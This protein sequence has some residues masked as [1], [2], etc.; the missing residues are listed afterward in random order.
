MKASG[1]K[2]LPVVMYHYVNDLQGGITVTA[3]CFEE[4]C[5]VLAQKG[6]RGIGLDEAE[7]FLINGKALPAR[8]LLL[9][10]DDGY[11]D[12][13]LNALPAMRR[14]GHRGVVFAVAGRLEPGAEPR[15]ALAK[16]LQG[17]A[18]VPAEV[19]VPVVQTPEGF[20]LRKDVF[21]NHAEAK[22]MDAEGT[23]RVA[24][25]SF[26]HYGVYLGPDYTGVS[27]PRTR[28]RTFYRTEQEPVWGLPEFKV[29]PGLLERA[30]IP[31]PSLV[32]AVKAL[33]PQE[34][35]AAAAFFAEGGACE[36]LA[37]L[38]AGFAGKL[39]RYESDA[40]RKERMWREL[41]GG[42]EALEMVLG[43]KVRT[44]CWPWGKYCGEALTLAREA[45]FEL[46]FS[47]KEG[48]N[49]PG[50]PLAVHRFKGKPKSGNWLLSR[51]RIYASPLLGSM[52][53]RLRI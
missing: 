22:A 21:L 34:F 43:H 7:D 5:R 38:L 15:A 53:A 50:R 12:N 44:L 11:L 2:S 39:G 23:L 9:T 32:E 29:G 10:F 1:S 16:V 51:V 42:K 26:G 6:W 47:T 49:P 31:D 45:G 24:S 46:F 41:A 36:E 40:E 28:Y 14:Y 52:Y 27:R 37:A 17:A 20:A 30:F 3:G 48:V 8:S 13:Y 18:A 19:A 35:S 25:H 33:V 4:H